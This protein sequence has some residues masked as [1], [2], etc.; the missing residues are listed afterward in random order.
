MGFTDGNT[1][2][3]NKGIAVVGSVEGLNVVGV[4]DGV[5]EEVIDGEVLGV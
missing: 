3:L 1:L 2:E 4:I 5:N